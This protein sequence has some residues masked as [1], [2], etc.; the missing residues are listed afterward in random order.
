MK[1]TLEPTDQLTELGIMGDVPVRLW[2]GQDDHG[3]PVFAFV[4]VVAVPEEAGA[5]AQERF[6][7]RLLEVS[8]ALDTPPDLPAGTTVN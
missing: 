6:G 4:A 3:T 1:L 2:R 5:E 8:L 7:Q